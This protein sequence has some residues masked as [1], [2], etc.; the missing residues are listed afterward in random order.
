MNHFATVAKVVTVTTPRPPVS[1]KSTE[2]IL[3]K[4]VYSQTAIVYGDAAK[5]R[6][7]AKQCVDEAKA[8]LVISEAALDIADEALAIASA[9]FNKAACETYRLCKLRAV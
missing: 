6:K 2:E 7:I 9:N 1:K 8:A 4:S 5:E 3:A